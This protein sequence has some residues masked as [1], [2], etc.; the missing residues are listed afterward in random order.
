M[1]GDGPARRWG[2]SQGE[3]W[4]WHH[5]PAPVL[6]EGPWGPLLL[7]T[8]KLCFVGVGRG[9]VSR[10]ERKA[11]KENNKPRIGDCNAGVK[12]PHSPMG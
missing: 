4:L 12:C 5:C 8:L 2:G 9:G 7:T 3:V 11:D 1:P 6:L 10:E